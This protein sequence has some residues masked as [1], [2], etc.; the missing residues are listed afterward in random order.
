MIRNLINKLFPLKPTTRKL[1]NG[2]VV[3]G[4]IYKIHPSSEVL[5]GE[6]CLIEG[7]LTTYTE[8]SKI[9]L[10]KG[11]FIGK[12]SIVGCALS[13]EI[14]NNVLISFDCV[15]QDSDTHST[16]YLRRRNDTTDWLN[17]TK[18]WN[19]IPSKPIT[20]GN[21]AWIGA[22]SNILKGIY[23]GAGAIIGAGSVVTKN[24][25]AFTIVAGN[26]AK[27]IKAIEH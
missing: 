18:D 6:N 19:N 13:I 26:P 4:V 25:D 1:E 21:D 11:V 8:N 23:I 9:R 14:G 27:F 22:R 7:V 16:D 5:T 3:K 17:G 15:I 24:V 20:I 2:T 12:N 10:G